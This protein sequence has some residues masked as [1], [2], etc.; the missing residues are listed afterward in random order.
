MFSVYLV[1]GC[2]WQVALLGHSQQMGPHVASQQGHALHV[3]T[4]HCGGVYVHGVCASPV[5]SCTQ[6]YT[7]SA[8][9]TKD[10]ENSTPM[11]ICESAWNN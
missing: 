1:G 7:D 3:H 10:R 4:V 6:V 9:A 5:A 8:N 2:G 11:Y